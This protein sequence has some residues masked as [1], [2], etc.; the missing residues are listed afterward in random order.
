M[1]VRPQA[2][3]A[4]VRVAGVRFRAKGGKSPICGSLLD[5]YRAR[6]RGGLSRTWHVYTGRRVKSGLCQRGRI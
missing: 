5:H 4:R 1:D 3:P 2:K 6:N